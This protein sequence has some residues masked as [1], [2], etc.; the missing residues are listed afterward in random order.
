MLPPDPALRT[1]KNCGGISVPLFGSSEAFPEAPSPY[2]S[3]YQ[4]APS[5]NGYSATGAL[6]AGGGPTPY[7]A[8]GVPVG[9]SPTG[10]QHP[11]LIILF[12]DADSP[13]SSRLF[14]HFAEEAKGYPEI[15][16]VAI[17]SFSLGF[18]A[19]I[20]DVCKEVPLPLGSPASFFLD[21][22]SFFNGQFAFEYFGVQPN[23]VGGFGGACR[24]RGIWGRGILRW[25]GGFCG[26]GG[27]N[28]LEVEGKFWKFSLLGESGSVCGIQCRIGDCWEGF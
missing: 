12:L 17:E 27:V 22:R 3:S 13:F 24:R 11:P 5:T 18:H 1:L 14:A 23:E 10:S 20:Q 26:D 25:R 19:N 16:F 2:G 9:T 6:G 21:S 8:G 15:K 28:G 4:S 7:S